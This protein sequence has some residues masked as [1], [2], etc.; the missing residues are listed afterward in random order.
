M[1]LL[2]S[3]PGSGIFY[4]AYEAAKQALTPH[5]SSEAAVGAIAG[6]AACLASLVVFNPMEVVKQRVMVQRDVGSAQ[7]LAAVLREGGRPDGRRI[8]RSTSG[9]RGPQARG[10]AARPDPPFP[11]R[12]RPRRRRRADDAPVV[13]Q[14]VGATGLGAR[15]AGAAASRSLCGG[16]DAGRG[17]RRL[18]PQHALLA[19]AE[20]DDRVLLDD[21]GRAQAPRGG[22]RRGGER[23]K[24]KNG[25]S[26][27]LSLRARS[28]YE[29]SATSLTGKASR[30]SD[31]ANSPNSP[32]SNSRG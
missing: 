12:L 21:A 9:V 24:G 28:I 29:F 31:R 13:K 1:H 11:A 6:A 17:R 5:L 8:F 2:A 30:G 32:E 23:R 18:L 14:Q 3:A 19:P 10:R 4:A 27:A 7:V 16:A 22:R 15:R 20:P 26:A 25:P